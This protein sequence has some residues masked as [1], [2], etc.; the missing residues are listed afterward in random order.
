M[1]RWKPGFKID[2]PNGGIYRFICK[3]N[4]WF[5]FKL[6]IKRRQN[7]EEKEAERQAANKLLQTLDKQYK[8]P[9]SEQYDTD[10]SQSK[11]EVFSAK[12]SQTKLAAVAAAAFAASTISAL[13]PTGSS[14][15]QSNSFVN[16]S[17]NQLILMGNDSATKKEDFK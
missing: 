16:N 17:L 1:L 3:K 4:I 2:E 10:K 8:K 12:S 9:N 13:S 7:A 6:L 5:L 15:S 11:Q 14:S